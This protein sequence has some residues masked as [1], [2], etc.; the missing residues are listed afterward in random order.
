MKKYIL[1]LTSILCISTMYSQDT[2]VV[3]IRPALTLPVAT[4]D[5]ATLEQKPQT[6]DSEPL[7]NMFTTN[8]SP[9]VYKGNIY[10]I[11]FRN[12]KTKH[13]LQIGQLD[14]TM[15]VTIVANGK[16]YTRKVQQY[17]LKMTD[18]NLD[19]GIIFNGD[20]IPQSSDVSITVNINN[21]NFKILNSNLETKFYNPKQHYQSLGQNLGGFW[22]PTLLYSTN[23]QATNDGIPFASLPIG[24]AYG[25]KFFGKRGNYV[26]ISGMGNWLIY[27]QT[28]STSANNTFNL[29][30]LTGG[31]L[32]DF[33]DVA[34]IGFAY[35]K[36]FKKGGSDP[37]FMFVLGIGSKALGFFKK[38]KESKSS[39]T[40]NINSFK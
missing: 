24:I 26:G 13:L 4:F 22:I 23:F 18:L 10:I 29:Q 38:D 6:V 12:L 35:G 28:S 31:L 15:S 27:N 33:S 1:I 36:N 40:F 7:K 11:R 5:P 34:S 32:L 20:N 17:E 3:I 37:G 14:A 8:N 2:L 9:V 21:S 39:S 16:I 19:F 30:G 25:W